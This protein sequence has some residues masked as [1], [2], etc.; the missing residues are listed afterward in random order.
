MV[1]PFITDLLRCGETASEYL[2]SRHK[3]ALPWPPWRNGNALD[4]YDIAIQRLRVRAPPEVFHFF[5]PA[6][7]PAEAHGG[8]R[9]RS[10]VL[11]WW[12]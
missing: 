6:T 9:R 11:Q 2:Y 4:F 12:Y 10:S 1:G 5:G 7:T 8:C 3:P